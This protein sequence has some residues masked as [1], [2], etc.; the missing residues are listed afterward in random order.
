V[1]CGGAAGPGLHGADLAL[2]LLVLRA[3][4][5]FHAGLPAELAVQRGELRSQQSTLI[6]RRRSDPARRERAR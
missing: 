6:H 3:E 2:H 1:R 4:R 5:L